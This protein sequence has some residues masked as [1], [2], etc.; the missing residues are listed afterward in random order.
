VTSQYSGLDAVLGAR[1]A[2]FDVDGTLLTGDSD[3]TWREALLK[4][5]WVKRDAFVKKSETF[6][7]QYP[8][9]D[10]D[11]DAYLRFVVRALAHQRTEDVRRLAER[12]VDQFVLPMIRPQML[13]ILNCYRASG[14]RI[15]VASATM[16]IIIAPLSR[17][18]GIESVIASRAEHYNGLYTGRAVGAA[19]CGFGKRRLVTAWL[20][21]VGHTLSEAAF[22]SDSHADL[23]LLDCVG[24]PIAVLPNARLRK[25]AVSRG[26]PILE[27]D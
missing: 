13:D 3:A 21:A 26:W 24:H 9:G 22:F 2:V 20:Q 7:R 14:A 25:H 1:A 17:R 27:F 11:G 5:G 18:L 12:T 23:P 15:A 10:F 8:D 6:A 19:A 16:E 4:E